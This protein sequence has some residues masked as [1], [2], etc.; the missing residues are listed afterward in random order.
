[1]GGAFALGVACSPDGVPP[2]T[3][4]AGEGT[5]AGMDAGGLDAGPAH[6]AGA[7]AGPS[8]D[9][10]TDAGNLADAGAADAGP[11]DAGLVWGTAIT[12]PPD[13]WTWV[14]FED[15]VCNDGSPLG[16][17]IDPS[18][19]S[20]NVLIYFNGGGACWDY[21]TCY[22]AK[23]ATMGPYPQTQFQSDL[24]AI[25]ATIDR[26]DP[27]NPFADW[28]FVFVP[29]CTG[30][31]H[32]GNNVATY[33]SGST[34]N[35]FFHKGH[36][37]FMAF[38]ARLGPTFPAPGKVAVVGDSAGGAGAVINY[39]S[40]RA[41]WPD[42]GMYLINDSLPFFPPSETPS[43]TMSSEITNWGIQPTLESICGSACASDFS[44]I[45]PALQQRF[46]SDS[47]AYMGYD[48]DQTMSAY[49]ET[50][51]QLFQIY[52]DDLVSQKLQPAGVKT[53]LVSGTGHT[54][55]WSWA[56]TTTSQGV[57][58]R[59]WVGDMMANDAGWTSTGP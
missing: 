46:P 4:D 55:L 57:N 10:G 34:S 1:M 21:F 6:D 13:T 29:Y 44:L 19:T 2:P 25:G 37:N 33:T 16:I 31:V 5:D 17:G 11:T 23:S 58:L 59:T 30:D 50:L 45:L 48:Q 27:L 41:Y 49:Y 12:A 15:S 36:A 40:A 26:T 22:I 43:A 18:S 24:A 52:L 53:F 28:N 47:M 8:A 42:A 35:T 51:Q 3:Q 20:S 32:A 39:A 9:A 14:P 54:I 7:D 56:T 38:L